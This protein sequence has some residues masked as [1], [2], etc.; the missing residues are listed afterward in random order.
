MV[1]KDIGAVIVVEKDQPI[2][3]ITER[4]VLERVI[5]ANKN[6]YKT[7]AKDVMS[8]PLMTIGGNQSMKDSFELMR[9]H[10]IRRLAVIENGVL[11]GLVTERRLLAGFLRQGY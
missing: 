4:N 1:D 5:M 10:K 6:V 11:I 2:G 3:I 8:T 7:K 9:E